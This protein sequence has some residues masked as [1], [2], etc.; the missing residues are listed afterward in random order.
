MVVSFLSTRALKR[1]WLL[2]RG[3]LVLK[4]LLRLGCDRAQDALDVLMQVCTS[5]PQTDPDM[6]LVLF[7]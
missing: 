6:N 5:Q 7:T 1:P 3:V 2:R 4:G